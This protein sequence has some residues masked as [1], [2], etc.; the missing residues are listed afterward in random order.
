MNEMFYNCSSICSLPDLWRWRFNRLSDDIGIFGG[1]FSIIDKIF[2][3][4]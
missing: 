2:K 1:C 3:D 4:K